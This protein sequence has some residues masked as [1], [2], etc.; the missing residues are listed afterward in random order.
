MKKAFKIFLAIFTI[1]LIILV[2]FVALIF[3]DLVAYTAT[4]SQLLQSSDTSLGKALVL[5]DPGL[6]GAATRVAQKV[7]TD[8]QAKKLTVML[9]GIKSSVAANTTGYDVIVIGG[10]IYAGGPTNSV[11]D[12]L[13]ALVLNHDQNA[14]IGIFGS[15]K[16]P[17]S[18][19]DVAQIRQAI[20][21][22]S[23]SSLRDAIVVKIGESEDLDA[24]AL[25]F[26]N[27][28]VG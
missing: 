18:P 2:A 10:P 15:G 28:L 21:I 16:G 7:A 23:D 22:R 6:T 11:K 8:L 25:D 12:T 1:L 4:S 26:V 27:Q 13:H 24:R 20:P 5:Y 14:R 17:T 19:E 3:L 9:A